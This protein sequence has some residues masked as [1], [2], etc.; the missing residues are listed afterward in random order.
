M[1]AT[2]SPLKRLTNQSPFHKQ[3]KLDKMNTPS[4]SPTPKRVKRSL[5]LSMM[6]GVSG[7]IPGEETEMHAATMTSTSAK[8]IMHPK[9]QV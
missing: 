6:P 7:S 2:P 5:G 3:R 8:L 1:S 4:K 9:T